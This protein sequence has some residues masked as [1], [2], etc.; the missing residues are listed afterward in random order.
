[1][2]GQR[3]Q[4]ARQGVAGGR[5]AGGRVPA[6]RGIAS[7]RIASERIAARGTVD[8]SGG[9]GRDEQ[10]RGGARE[11]AGHAP[12]RLRMNSVKSR[13]PTAVGP[14]AWCGPS[15]SVY[16]VPAMSRCTQGYPSTNSRR[17]HPPAIDPAP[18]PPEF[19]TSAM[20]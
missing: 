3:G 2:L 4:V 8:L 10:Q 17:N 5:V 7:E 19:F 13:T 9:S 15:P 20:S 18:R 11:A 14:L 6:G 16:A 1:Q 12:A